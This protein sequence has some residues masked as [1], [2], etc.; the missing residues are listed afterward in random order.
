MGTV[1]IILVTQMTSQRVYIAFRWLFIPF[2]M[3]WSMLRSR[4]F[5]ELKTENPKDIRM[6]TEWLRKIWNMTKVPSDPLISNIQASSHHLSIF[7][8]F[9]PF[10]I[11]KSNVD[12]RSEIDWQ[13]M[14]CGNVVEKDGIGLEDWRFFLVLSIWNL[15]LFY[16]KLLLEVLSRVFLRILLF[17]VILR[18]WVELGRPR[19]E[20]LGI[21]KPRLFV[22]SNDKARCAYLNS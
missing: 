3:F 20:L 5:I 19:L 10:F 9:P 22:S 14:P 17:L 6:T 7:L 12:I 13:G 4:T 1:K 16:S 18:Y 11:T 21:E 15:V 2:E 8:D